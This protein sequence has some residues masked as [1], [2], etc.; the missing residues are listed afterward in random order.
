[1]DEIRCAK[2]LHYILLSV[3]D[4]ILQGVR[5]FPNEG[6][7]QGSVTDIATAIRVGAMPISRVETLPMIWSMA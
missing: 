3:K 5:R 7:V 2:D 6:W 4:D 1:M